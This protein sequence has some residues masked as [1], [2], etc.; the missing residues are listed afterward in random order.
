M[1][2]YLCNDGMLM[3]YVV[4][5]NTIINFVN[6]TQLYV[7]YTTLS[8]LHKFETIKCH[9]YCTTPDTCNRM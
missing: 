8:I 4:Q 9:M 1:C 5:D 3:V 6:T 2:W 7:Y